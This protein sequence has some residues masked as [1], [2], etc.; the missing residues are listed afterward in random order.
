MSHGAHGAPGQT[1]IGKV[2]SFRGEWGFITSDSLEGNWALERCGSSGYFGLLDQGLPI[3]IVFHFF[4]WFHRFHSWLSRRIFH[5]PT[6]IQKSLFLFSEML[7]L[8]A[9]NASSMF[10]DFLLTVWQCRSATTTEVWRQFSSI[11]QG[12]VEVKLKPA[13]TGWEDSKSSWCFPLGITR[14]GCGLE[15]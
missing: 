3:F 13:L 14:H 10:I 5:G 4:K 11:L 1:C 15:F 8:I 9:E 12:A 7:I 2:K 6:I